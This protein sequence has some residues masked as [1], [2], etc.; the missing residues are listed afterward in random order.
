MGRT[1][2]ESEVHETI[3]DTNTVYQPFA[4]AATAQRAPRFGGVSV[5]KVGR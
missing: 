4:L 1:F 3:R 5:S 2:L